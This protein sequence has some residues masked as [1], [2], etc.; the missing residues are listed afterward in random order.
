M[1]DKLKIAA[2]VCTYNR[3]D[4][5]NNVLNSLVDQTL[6][7]A[8]YEVIV[9]DNASTDATRAVVREFIAKHPGYPVRYL[10]E[11]KQGLS[12]ARNTGYKNS[13]AAYITYLDDDAKA[14]PDFLGKV[15]HAFETVRPTPSAVGGQI[16]PYYLTPKPDW[17]L[18]EYELHTWGDT[19]GFLKIPEQKAGFDGSN[20]SFPRAILEEYQGFSADFGMTG[21]KKTTM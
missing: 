7:K 8:F 20:M 10:Y 13:S 17:F 11:E 2:V 14:K 1:S 3:C 18:D 4:L 16:V 9:V 15:V 19:K 5:M 6:D 12:H 21:K